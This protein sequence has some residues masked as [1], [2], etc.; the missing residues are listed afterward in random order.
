MS[1]PG[2]HRSE[3]RRAVLHH[4]GHGEAQAF[5]TAG[6]DPHSRVEPHG[7]G[8]GDIDSP[9]VLLDARSQNKILT[10]SQRSIDRG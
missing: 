4:V 2:P 5:P 8:V 6:Q 9:A 3:I 10:G 7:I 1:W